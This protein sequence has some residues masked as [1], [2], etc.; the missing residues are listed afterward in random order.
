LGAVVGGLRLRAWVLCC[1]PVTGD[2]KPEGSAD[3]QGE[4]QRLAGVIGPKRHADRPAMGRRLP[5]ECRSSVK[6]W[7]VLRDTQHGSK[8]CTNGRR[9]RWIEQPG[10]GWLRR[11]RR[12]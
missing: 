11:R 2:S 8:Q 4:M 6:G 12:T 1:R 7:G 10:L 5:V 3:K 9:Q